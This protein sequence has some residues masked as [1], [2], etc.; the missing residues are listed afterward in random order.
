MKAV[1]AQNHDG[2]AD[3]SF[4]GLH[5][6][7]VAHGQFQIPGTSLLQQSKFFNRHISKTEE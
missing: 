5:V 2:K 1:E 3:S 6:E 7:M 4:K